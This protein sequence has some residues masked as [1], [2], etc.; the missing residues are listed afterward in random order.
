MAKKQ[1]KTVPKKLY[2][3]ASDRYIAGVCGGLGKFFDIDP[4]IFRLLFLIITAFGGA[5]VLVYIILWILVPEE[6]EKIRPKD[7]GE[8]IKEGANKMAQE[9]KTSGDRRNNSRIIG[10]TIVVLIGA[11]FLLETLFPGWRMG[12]G[13]LWPLIIIAI[14]LA[15]IFGRSRDQD[16]K[17]DK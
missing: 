10:G 2:R 6:G 4:L 12:F 16:K 17:E 5:G 3:S 15:I 11:I 9:M 7:F 1:E 8:N 14:G 13:R